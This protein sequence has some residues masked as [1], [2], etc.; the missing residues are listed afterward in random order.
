MGANGSADDIEEKY[1]ERMRARDEILAER[2][3]DGPMPWKQNDWQDRRVSE[4]RE[5]VFDKS[6][7]TPIYPIQ[8]ELSEFTLTPTHQDGMEPLEGYMGEY[9]RPLRHYAVK[10]HGAIVGMLGLYKDNSDPNDR[11]QRLV[12]VPEDPEALLEKTFQD[13]EAKSGEKVPRPHYT[14]RKKGTLSI[15]QG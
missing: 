14:A 7:V 6:Y 13:Y 5:A 1:R 2:K 12:F 8:A 15:E 11:T 3:Y 4:E 10:Y 9:G